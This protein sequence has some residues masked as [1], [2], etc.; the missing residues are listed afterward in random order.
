MKSENTNWWEL[1]GGHFDI[2]TGNV[3]KLFELHRVIDSSSDIGLNEII[4]EE[5]RAGGRSKGTRIEISIDGYSIRPDLDAVSDFML[6]L[7]NSPFFDDCESID[8]GDIVIKPDSKTKEEIVE[9]TL[10]VKMKAKE[11]PKKVKKPVRRRPAQ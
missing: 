3:K 7:K 8:P 11:P 9:F 1:N 5:K 2:I 10:T 6:A 4:I